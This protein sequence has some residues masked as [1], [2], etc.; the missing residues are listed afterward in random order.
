MDNC[1]EDGQNARNS[2]KFLDICGIATWEEVR[3]QIQDYVV[4]EINWRDCS[5]SA[6]MVIRLLE[7]LFGGSTKGKG[8]KEEVSAKHSGLYKALPTYLSQFVRCTW[9]A[10][11]RQEKR[12]AFLYA[13]QLYMTASFF[14]RKRSLSNCAQAG[15]R[16]SASVTSREAVLDSANYAT[17]EML[18]VLVSPNRL[19]HQINNFKH[20]DALGS[21]IEDMIKQGSNIRSQHL[22]GCAEERFTLMFKLQAMWRVLSLHQMPS[23]ETKKAK[24]R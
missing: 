3:L 22:K 9:P 15:K 21:P 19:G 10:A 14:C 13:G 16:K 2:Q 24:L 17:G 11:A 20:A 12:L 4:Y 18:I 7:S 1:V 6:C 5:S 8:Y 23:S